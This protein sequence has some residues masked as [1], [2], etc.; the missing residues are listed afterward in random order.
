MISLSCI[1]TVLQRFVYSLM[2]G[3]EGYENSVGGPW[4]KK[5]VHHKVSYKLDP[6][7]SLRDSV[8][9][10]TEF[11]TAIARITAECDFIF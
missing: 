7:T 8:F 1:A 6:K 10:A 3:P 4:P 9:F 2:C 11:V 5:F